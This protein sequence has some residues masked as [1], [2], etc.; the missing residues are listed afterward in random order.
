MSFTQ[1]DYGKKFR[2]GLKRDKAKHEKFKAEATKRKPRCG[3]LLPGKVDLSS[4]V[5]PPEDQG[6][7]GACWDFSITKALRSAFMLAGKDPGRLAF[8]YLLNNC[9]GVPD[10]Q[11]DGCNGGDFPAGLGC[12]NGK[13]PWLESADPYQAAGGQC[14]NLPTAASGKDWVLV[15]DGKTPPTFQQLAEA[16]AANHMLSVDVDAQGGSW[17]NYSGGI[18]NEDGG[19]DIDHMINLVGYDMETSVDA[20]GNAVFNAQ[21]QPINGDGYLIVEN[22]WNTTWGEGGYMRTRWGKNSIAETA[23]Y[24]TTDVV[25]PTPPV[26]PVP[27]VP[28]APGPAPV[29][30]GIPLWAYIAMGVLGAGVLVLGGVLLLKKK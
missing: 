29:N 11:F 21:G 22:N 1:K 10:A 14:A 26:P 16:V 4:K 12:I 15:G 24:F 23:M 8:N 18:Y 20:N 25:P 5:S 28:P 17:M 9:S 3:V 7:C 2:T 27:P 6:Q 13:G 30:N 19:S